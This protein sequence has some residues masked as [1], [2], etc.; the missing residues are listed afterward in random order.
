MSAL[1]FSV[2]VAA[3]MT[4]AVYTSAARG[5]VLAAGVRYVQPSLVSVPATAAATASAVWLFGTGPVIRLLL[6]AFIVDRILGALGIWLSLRS[7]RT[8]L[9]AGAVS[10]S[11]LWII[12]LLD[13]YW[14]VKVVLLVVLTY[15][16]GSVDAYLQRQDRQRSTWAR[17]ARGADW[18][19]KRVEDG[20]EAGEFSLYLRPFSS[21]NRLPAQMLVGDGDVADYLDVETVLANAMPWRCPL[22]GIGAP[23]A[24]EEMPVGA[25]LVQARER[26]RDTVSRLAHGATLVV[27]VPGPRE[28]TLWEIEWLYRNGQ[29]GKALFVMPE[30]ARQAPSGVPHLVTV[31]NGALGTGI[32]SYKQADHTLDYAAE[33]AEAA[34]RARRFGVHLPPYA[35]AGALFTL[36]PASGRVADIVPLALSVVA[37]PTVYLRAALRGLG[38]ASRRGTATAADRFTEMTDAFEASLLP[39]RRSREHALLVA[40]EAYRAWGEHERASRLLHRA[41]WAA[42]GWPYFGNLT[43]PHRPGETRPPASSHAWDPKTGEYGTYMERIFLNRCS[44]VP[45][46]RDLTGRRR[47]MAVRVVVWG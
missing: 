41:E 42:G 15:P 22:V 12:E 33:W 37:H 31:E 6:L 24:P 3:W 23:G 21:T 45:F 39:Y 1:L 19:V 18:I 44:L 34:E 30:T 2:D 47:M 40:A 46:F 26:W 11:A 4:L 43:G 16:L 8:A 17:R 29:L 25:G 10:L 27:V 7:V 20:A 36:D 38:L 35:E 32:G 13:A 28:G 14:Y 5:M 9:T